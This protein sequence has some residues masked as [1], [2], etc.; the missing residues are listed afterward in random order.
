MMVIN[1]RLTWKRRRLLTC[2]TTQLFGLVF[3]A[4]PLI[5]INQIW[6]GLDLEFV[7]HDLKQKFNDQD[8]TWRHKSTLT[9]YSIFWNCVFNCLC[10]VDVEMAVEA[11]D[12]LQQVDPYR[13]D[14]MDTYSN[15]LYVKVR[16]RARL[17]AYVEVFF[18]S[19]LFGLISRYCFVLFIFT[20]I[21]RSADF[22]Y[23]WILLMNLTHFF[24][25]Q[26]SIICDWKYRYQ[27]SCYILTGNE[28]G[29]GIP[30]TSLLRH[31]QVSGGNLLHYRWEHQ[32]FTLHIFTYIYIN[33]C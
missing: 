31:R 21:S 16:Y 29:D 26:S 14:N 1:K 20:V 30:G 27:A 8:L 28:G 5:W 3:D 7:C 17:I 9:L 13:L 24:E 6:P 25:N 12:R 22:L 15:L 23:L 11:F 2:Y 32:A 18:W 19:G 10:F 4:T 33:C